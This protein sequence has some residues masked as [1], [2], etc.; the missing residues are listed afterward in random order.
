MAFL[1]IVLDIRFGYDKILVRNK[2]EVYFVKYLDDQRS[3]EE[4]ENNGISPA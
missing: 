1:L 4:A 3:L 2:E